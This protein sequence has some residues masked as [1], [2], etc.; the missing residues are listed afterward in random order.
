MEIMIFEITATL[1][2]AFLYMQGIVLIDFII[3]LIYTSSYILEN[4]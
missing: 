2:N 4:I 1:H 3:T